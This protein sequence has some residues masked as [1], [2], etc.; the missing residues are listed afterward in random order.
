QQ[1]SGSRRLIRINK[2]AL[3]KGA[4]RMVFGKFQLYELNLT[5]HLENPRLGLGYTEIA[6]PPDIA[7]YQQIIQNSL[8]PAPA[9][10]RVDADGNY[11]ARY[12]LKPLEKRDVVWE[13]WLA[14]YYPKRNF[15]NDK[16]GSLPAELVSRFTDAQKYWET[17]SVEIRTEAAKL[18]DPKLSAAE[19]L[20]EIYDFVT[21]K[22][23][24]NYQKL[25]S[26]ELVRLG[27]LAS[28]SQTDQAVCMEYTDLFIAIARAAG[29]PAR[30][31]NGYAYTIDDTNRPLSL[32][33][34][35]DVLHAW[36]QVYLP[37]SGWTMVDPTWGSTSGSDYFSAF[38][39]SHLAFIVRGDSS[40][41]PLPA[42]SYKTDPNQKDVLVEFSTAEE[43]VAEKPQ[44]EVGIELSPFI[45]SPFATTAQV[46]VR[47]SGKTTAFGT[48]AELAS[49]LLGI[50][51]PEL[52]LGTLPPG[53]SASY[54]VELTSPGW[55][56]RG[57]ERLTAGVS[58]EDFNGKNLTANGE[59]TELVRPLYWPL[60]LPE[61]GVGIG[62]G[63]LIFFSR[64]IFAA[65]IART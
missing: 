50:E 14:L 54:E 36:P 23:S 6:L 8:L 40:E 15:S 5:Y 63:L 17:G 21:G 61:I 16:L 45:L 43:A 4:P 53:A 55:I 56:T 29:I 20:R 12:N 18:A 24:Y 64:K 62:F 10:I 37:E 51:D 35:G 3:L 7:G 2:A 46:T 42:G 11:L 47:N 27:A 33:V 49:D 9:S 41:Y 22:L 25:E 58:A 60:R 57:Q 59:D 32:R 26:G 65:R 38:D 48:T 52:D 39:L 31:V 44:L 30:E 1:V 28:L 13:G 19:I 34:E